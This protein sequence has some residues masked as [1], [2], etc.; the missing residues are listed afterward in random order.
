MASTGV[1]GDRI[2]PD[3]SKVAPRVERECE[4][5]SGAETKSERTQFRPG[6]LNIPA[7]LWLLTGGLL[8]SLVLVT[9]YTAVTLS[10]QRRDGGTIN[11]AG[12]QRM[13]TQKLSKTVMEVRSGHAK[14]EQIDQIQK[15]FDEVLTGLE[16]GSDELGLQAQHDAETKR[17]LAKVREMW[18]PFS[19]QIDTIKESWPRIIADLHYVSEN[20]VTLFNHANRLVK[21]LSRKSDAGTVSVAGRLRAITQRVSKAV[22]LF[23]MLGDAPSREEGLTYLALQDRILL[24]LL[25]GDSKLG[26]RASRDPGVR[27]KIIEFQAEWK[28]FERAAKGVLEGSDAGHRAVSYIYE[29]NEELL[30]AMNAAVQSIAGHSEAKVYRMIRA[31]LVILVI[32]LLIGG[33]ATL[34]V[35]RGI[36]RPLALVSERVERLSLGVISQEAVPVTSRDETGRLC[37]AF[38]VFLDTLQQVA[39]KLKQIAGGDLEVRFDAQSEQDELAHAHNEMA[40]ALR[41]AAREAAEER[42]HVLEAAKRE[43]AQ[44]AEQERMQREQARRDREAAEEK[45]RLEQERAQQ[46]MQAAEDRTKIER[47]HAEKE[48]L[49][50]QELQDKVN[51]ILEAVDA[52]AKGDLTHEV[53]VAGSDAIGQMGEGFSKF[54][55]DLRRSVESIGATAQRLAAASEEVNVVSAT[56]SET[57]NSTSQRSAEVS[58]AADQVS[59]NVSTVATGTEEMAVTIR[60]VAR[61]TSEASQVAAEAVRLAEGTSET[62]NLLGEQSAEIGQVIKVIDAIAE[63]TNLLALNATIEAA[64]AGEAGKG[65]GVVANEVKALANDTSKATEE[66]RH[67]ISGIQQHTEGTVQAIGKIS[68]IIQKI[69]EIQATIASTVEEQAV[70]SEEITRNVAEA[71]AGIGEIAASI[72]S[73]AKD[74][75]AAASGAKETNASAGSMSAMAGE[76]QE[77]VSEFQY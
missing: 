2:M 41:R 8:L 54:L 59:I 38:N 37:V 1:G 20:N 9:S 46:E 68:E 12:A 24:G 64:R 57:A 28:P 45:V 73:V 67:K 34:T 11:L 56:M 60:E 13:L 48:R 35:V 75:E 36:T 5:A 63:Q 69:D 74:A 33:G 66:I 49:A 18:R 31:E 15:R 21:E 19:K 47:E 39:I 77:L 6:R 14:L 55:A 23:G 72:A 4:V 53:T 30:K 58:A 26:V 52:A 29:H 61:A 51:A 22:L 40:H 3:R 65:F 62:V 27:R 76:L 50:A 44:A 43:K 71:A 32:L 70:T 7:K 25:N 42:A 16:S 17:L 10:S